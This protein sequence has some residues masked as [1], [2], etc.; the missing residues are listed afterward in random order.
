MPTSTRPGRIVE[1]ASRRAARRRGKPSASG[2]LRLA[3]DSQPAARPGRATRA[4]GHD[5]RPGAPAASRPELFQL[6]LNRRLM[7]RPIAWGSRSRQANVGLQRA[8]RFRTLTCSFSRTRTRTIPYGK[9]SGTSWAVGITVPLPVYNRNQGN[10][11]RAKINVIPDPRCSWPTREARVESE[12]RQAIKEY[13][14]SA[15]RSPIA[16]ASGLAR[17][18]RAADGSAQAVPG[19]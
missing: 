5:R 3:E 17:L 19:R 16:S 8:N 14:V 9:Q 13:Q 1:I 12:V 15:V 2:N 11:E 6:A 7:W 10:I 18:R 4:A